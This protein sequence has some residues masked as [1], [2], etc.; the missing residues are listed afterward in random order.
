[1]HFSVSMNMQKNGS[2]AVY[3]RVVGQRSSQQ[4][5]MFDLPEK[6]VETN[7]R[8]AHGEAELMG[9]WWEFLYRKFYK[10]IEKRESILKLLCIG[11]S[12]Q[13]SIQMVLSVFR[14]I[15]LFMASVLWRKRSSG[16]EESCYKESKIT[17]KKNLRSIKF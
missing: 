9:D 5:W 3:T 7:F 14:Y 4:D 10:I 12:K 13:I 15:R 8:L 17:G 16:S 6:I 2:H 11:G 1:M